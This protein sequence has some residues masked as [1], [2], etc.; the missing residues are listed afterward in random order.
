MGAY[1]LD[2]PYLADKKEE[3]PNNVS[4]MRPNHCRPAAS[5]R[6]EKRLLCSDLVRIRWVDGQG[7]R[8][9]EI[10]VLE[11]Y[12][13]SGA[14]MLMGLPIGEG[15]PVTLCGREEEYRATVRH[16]GPAP[17]GYLVGLSFGDQPRNYV[18]E[19]LLDVL[20]LSYPTEP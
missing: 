20:L 19:H 12:S 16:C 18:P 15:T 11:G 9:E 5:K 17:N 3:M 6:S 13:A 8:R 1:L 2:A 10:V 14:S 7:A 4:T